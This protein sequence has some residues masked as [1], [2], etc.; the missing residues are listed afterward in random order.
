MPR[1]AR[2][3]ASAAPA[4]P[5]PTFAEDEDYSQ[6]A[7]KDPTDK[8]VWFH[9]WA[10]EATGLK[11]D[12][13]S[14]SLGP[15]LYH[16]FQASEYNKQM[17]A[18]KRAARDAESNGSEPAEE[19]PAKPTRRGR[20]AK[21]ETAAAEDKP[22]GTRGRRGAAAAA[23]DGKAGPQ[24]KPPATGRR[25]GRPAGSGAKASGAAPF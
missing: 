25:R 8:M 12:L 20:Q 23:G 3:T 10:Q 9:I 16:F 6:Y 21:T 5:T 13:K 4:E 17:T 15:T 14:L 1:G 22:T 19:E 18:A 2:A 7:E 24:S 11:L